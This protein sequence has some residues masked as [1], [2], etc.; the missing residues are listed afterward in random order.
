MRKLDD[1]RI[2]FWAND[3]PRGIEFLLMQNRLNVAISRAKWAAYLIYSPDLTEFLL[4]NVRDLKLL[5]KFI[6]LTGHGH[7]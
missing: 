2:I 3:V 6:T 4:P 5:S 7:A 1:G